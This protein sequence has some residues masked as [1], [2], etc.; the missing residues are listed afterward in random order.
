LDISFEQRIKKNEA[1]TSRIKNE[2]IGNQ[3]L[4]ELVSMPILFLT[5]TYLQNKS[6]MPQKY[7]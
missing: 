7:P 1:K 3:Q 2:S 6:S 5:K 4:P